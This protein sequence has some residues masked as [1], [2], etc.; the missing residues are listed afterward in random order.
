MEDRLLERL[1]H[2]A[3]EVHRALDLGA[4]PGRATRALRDALPGAQVVAVDWALALLRQG[5]APALCADLRALPVATGSVDL[6]FSSLAM[7]WV[8]DLEGWFGE[9]RR[10]LRP[11]GVWLFS[12]FGPDTLIELRS[13]WAAVDKAPHVHLFPDMHDL[14]D[15]LLRAGFSNPVMDREYLALT[16]P[17]VDGL[18]ADLRALGAQNAD[19]GRRR[20][21]TGKGQLAAMKA[22]Y[23]ALSDDERIT[24]S[25]ELVFGAALAPQEGQPIRTP[26]GEV[27]H[28]SVESLRKPRG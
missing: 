18:M 4:G 28:F 21:L 11:G 7:P 8:H 14:G 15:A 20:S 24:A 3:P 16:Y 26:D 12:T 19:A 2:F 23:E 1:D 17:D 9:I 25:H 6:V 5:A 13:A 10:V 27:A 22:A